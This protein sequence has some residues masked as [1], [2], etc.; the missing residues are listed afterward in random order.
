MFEFVGVILSFNPPWPW[1]QF[2]VE[3]EKM[4][5]KSF[6]FCILNKEQARLQILSTTVTIQAF[7]GP[8]WG[9]SNLSVQS[10]LLCK[11]WDP[12]SVLAG[13]TDKKKKSS[14]ESVT[15]YFSFKCRLASSASSDFSTSFDVLLI[16]LAFLTFSIT[17][18]LSLHA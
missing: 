4:T 16:K 12:S 9:Q 10:N 11:Q 1:P 7:S 18:S 8:H 5:K 15:W 2:I 17:V 3:G 14:E 6:G 13:R